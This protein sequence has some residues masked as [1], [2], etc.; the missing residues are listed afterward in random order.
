V[1]VWGCVCRPMWGD[2]VD[3]REQ[4]RAGLVLQSRI[5]LCTHPVS[6]IPLCRLRRRAHVQLLDHTIIS[7]SAA[8]VGHPMVQGACVLVH[9]VVLIVLKL[10]GLGCIVWGR[11]WG[12]APGAGESPW[13]DMSCV[14]I[15]TLQLWWARMP[16]HSPHIPP[17]WFEVGSRGGIWYLVSG[18]WIQCWALLCV[19]LISC[20]CSSL[21][22]S[23]LLVL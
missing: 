22:S 16:F 15:T 20:L 21:P 18:S 11:S 3:T 13:L 6:L 4:E 23:S 17:G 5:L 8:I 19:L 7:G 2:V 14:V 1:W 12:L 9:H 10:Q